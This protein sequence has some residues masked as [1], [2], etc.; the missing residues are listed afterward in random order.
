MVATGVIGCGYNYP[1]VRL[2]IHCG[3]FKSFPTFHQEF[4]RLVWDGKLGI[5]QV[6]TNKELCAEA[7]HIDPSFVEPNAWIMD[8]NNC[9][10]HGLHMF[11][12]GQPQWCSLIPRIEP[13]DNCFRHLRT[14]SPQPPTP[15]LMLIMRS[16]L[17]TLIHDWRSIVIDQH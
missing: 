1:Y 4:G 8:T 14:M 15:M 6:V 17:I 12:D 16:T 3:S 5:S 7:M 13:C 11:V 10:R 9:R 2:V